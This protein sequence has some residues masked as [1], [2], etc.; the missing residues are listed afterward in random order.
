MS[1]KGMA[2][3]STFAVPAFARR[4][5][6]SRL[7]WDSFLPYV[8]TGFAFTDGGGRSVALNLADIVEYRTPRSKAA[9]D[10]LSF[11][12][13]FRGPSR[14]GLPEGTY[15][16]EHFALGKFDLFI[17]PGATS[18]KQQAYR[19]VVNRVSV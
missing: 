12:L 7:D 11:T 2:V 17:A 8:G 6:L 4:D 16:V 13:I 3:G 15:S 9:A 18:G 14:K 1:L 19:A 10:K 5:G